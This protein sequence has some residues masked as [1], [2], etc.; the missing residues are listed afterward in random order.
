MSSKSARRRQRKARQ[1]TNK[2]Q[3]ES[4]SIN[5]SKVTRT[6]IS[7][8]VNY[9]D[10]FKIIE[11]P[12]KMGDILL[13]GYVRE[14]SLMNR[15]NFVFPM[16]IL[17]LCL[18]Y[19]I[20]HNHN[21]RAID[22]TLWSVAIKMKRDRQDR[23]GKSRN[24]EFKFNETFNNLWSYDKR[25]V[26]KRMLLEKKLPISAVKVWPIESCENEYHKEIFKSEQFYFLEY[27]LYKRYNTISSLD[28]SQM[29]YYDGDIMY[30]LNSIQNIAKFISDKNRQKLMLKTQS[31][32]TALK[33]SK[34]RQ[35]KTHSQDNIDANNVKHRQRRTKKRGDLPIF[36]KNRA[37]QKEI[38]RQLLSR[39]K[40]SKARY[41][42]KSKMDN[43]EFKLVTL[44]LSDNNISDK[45][46]PLLLRTIKRYM[47]NLKSLS[48][49]NTN[50]SNKSLD[51]IMKYGI[52]RLRIDLSKCKK[53]TLKGLNKYERN[54]YDGYDRYEKYVYCEDMVYFVNDQEKKQWTVDS[55]FDSSEVKGISRVGRKFRA[56]RSFAPIHGY[57]NE[58]GNPYD[59]Y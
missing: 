51:V 53:V 41:I 21:T 19:F 28:L 8:D 25:L 14:N 58:R 55:P 59:S 50:I 12:I 40:T 29:K 30:L 34:K 13:H 20:I 17:S 49:S 3:S 32:F 48:L 2:Q 1:N 16:E 5:K 9:G 52:R 57:Y 24:I 27:M 7:D 54:G 10:E 38:E 6:H 39:G 44:I 18:D 31:N 33:S 43:I 42:P 36:S 11:Q 47:P 46:L 56:N 15:L 4:K 23:Q 35:Q 26:Y 45:H 22:D 37:A